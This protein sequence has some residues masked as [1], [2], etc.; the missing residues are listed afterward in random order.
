MNAIKMLCNQNIGITFMYR[1][2]VKKEISQGY[3]TEIS[4]SDFNVS[5]PFNFVYL[6]DSPDKAQIEYWYEKIVTLRNNK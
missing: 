6:K 3:L 1:E 4:I 5:H 2:A